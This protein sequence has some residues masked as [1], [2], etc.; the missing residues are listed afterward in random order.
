ML[1]ITTNFYYL[2]DIFYYIF[3]SKEQK[4]TLPFHFYFLKQTKK[5]AYKKYKL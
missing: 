3:Y 4:R 1:Y 5:L 2:K